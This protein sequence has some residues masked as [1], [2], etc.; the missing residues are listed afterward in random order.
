[1]DTN[2]RPQFSGRN[3]DLGREI[4]G[5]YGR[6]RGDIRDPK[7][8]GPE[9]AMLFTADV[10]FTSFNNLYTE[11]LKEIENEVFY[12]NVKTLTQ[13]FYEDASTNLAAA[14]TDADQTKWRKFVTTLPCPTLCFKQ[15]PSRLRR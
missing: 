6:T 12:P 2:I 11:L 15:P 10:F 8:R 1:M 9:N 7:L 14:T 3:A 5:L 4:V 13:K